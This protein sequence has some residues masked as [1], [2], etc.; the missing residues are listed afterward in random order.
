MKEKKAMKCI[1][2]SN[3]DGVGGVCFMLKVFCIKQK[4]FSVGNNSILFASEIHRDRM[5]N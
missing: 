3:R 2:G 5:L 1:I 4:V